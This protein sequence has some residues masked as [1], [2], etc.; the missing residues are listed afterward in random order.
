[1]QETQEMRVWSVGGE[2]P[3]EEEMAAHSNILAWKIPWTEDPGGLQPKGSQWV[4]RDWA[5]MQ[6]PS[7]NFLC[8]SSQTHESHGHKPTSMSGDKKN[9]WSCDLSTWHWVDRWHHEPTSFFLYE[10]I[11]MLKTV[12]LDN[13]KA[14]GG[15][16]QSAWLG[17][18]NFILVPFQSKSSISVSLEKSGESLGLWN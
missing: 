6:L 14:Y 5:C 8:Q 11:K 16:H 13:K 10:F 2:D 15:H 3:L 17:N 1:M 7:H 9:S 18:P 4:R 12:H